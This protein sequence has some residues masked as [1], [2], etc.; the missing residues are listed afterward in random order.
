MDSAVSSPANPSTGRATSP[1]R[2][3]WI[4]GV[5]AGALLLTAVPVAVRIDRHVRAS[6]VDPFEQGSIGWRLPDEFHATRVPV[7]WIGIPGNSVL[8]K[9]HV[10]VVP[11]E[12]PFRFT[13]R[14]RSDETITITALPAGFP[15]NTVSYRAAQIN[16]TPYASGWGWRPFRPFRLVPDQEVSI[17]Y[18]ITVNRCMRKGQQ[19]ITAAFPI[20]YSVLGVS[21]R[22]DYVPDAQLEIMAPS[23]PREVVAAPPAS[24]PGAT[25]ACPRT[26]L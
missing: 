16:R 4:A 17:E 9:V 14:N 2:G 5:I 23:R 1:W 6:R 25:R 8:I 18:T 12:I 21:E 26:R 11:M 24:F 22:R 19:V 7:Q 15:D 20:V 10:V 3:R 13:L